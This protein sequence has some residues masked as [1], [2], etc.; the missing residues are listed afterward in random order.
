MGIKDK[1][2]ETIKITGQNISILNGKV[3]VNGVEYVP[4]QKGVTELEF[5]GDAGNLDIDCSISIK[6]N[7]IGTIDAGGSVNIVG[8]VDG[9]IDSGGSVNISGSHKGDIDAGGSVSI[10]GR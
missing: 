9:D 7:V 2:K 10:I 4:K 5:E 8:N 3:F 1:I 6:G